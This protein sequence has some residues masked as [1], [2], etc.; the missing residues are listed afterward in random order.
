MSYGRSIF[1]F[2]RNL[3]TGFCYGCIHLHPH[4]QC[5]R[6]PPFCPNLCQNLLFASSMSAI[7][8]GVRWGL[9]MLNYISLVVSEVELFILDFL[10]ASCIL[11]F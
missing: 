9:S 3:P 8:T 5:I 6:A 7:L 1:S 11:S 10:M 4:Q 2:W